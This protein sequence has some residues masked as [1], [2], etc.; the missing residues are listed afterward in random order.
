MPHV[1]IVHDIVGYLE[2]SL[3]RPQK[4]EQS[5]DAN[6]D[7]KHD[8]GQ[9]QEAADDDDSED[10]ELFLSERSVSDNEVFYDMPTSSDDDDDDDF[11][12]LNDSEDEQEVDS[13]AHED[14]DFLDEDGKLD[15][16]V[17]LAH[18]L[19]VLHE[20]QRCVK[21]FLQKNK[22]KNNANT[23]TNANVNV[24][25]ASTNS[26][27]LQE[28]ICI[29]GMEC[30]QNEL[31]ELYPFWR[32]W[33]FERFLCCKFDPFSNLIKIRYDTEPESESQNSVVSKHPPPV[34]CLLGRNN[35]DMIRKPKCC[36]DF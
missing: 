28:M 29:I 31:I 7:E 16:A 19:P 32:Q 17:K 5:D 14:E 10:V 3:F 15:Y 4:E 12:E 2:Q 25:G 18:L 24:N 22:N 11:D 20:T 27:F 13:S 30:L 6:G 9:Q 1:I 34:Y 35:L 26:S 23:N 36:P 33:N 8:G 21:Q